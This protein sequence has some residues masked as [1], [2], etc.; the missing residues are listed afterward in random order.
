MKRN[1]VLV[2]GA[3]AALLFGVA[4]APNVSAK[5]ARTFLSSVHVNADHTATFPLRHGVTSA[6]RL[7]SWRTATSSTE[8]DSCSDVSCL[9]SSASIA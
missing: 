9:A 4:P 2:I 1:C 7:R 8:C 5:S 6:P 3:A